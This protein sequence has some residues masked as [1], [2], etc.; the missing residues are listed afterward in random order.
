M[1]FRRPYAFLIKYFKII[2]FIL[3]FLLIYIA[4]KSY[5]I[6][7][8]FNEYVTHNYSGN[9]YKNFYIQYISPITI[10]AF[11]IILI[12]SA[13]VL[14]LLV[15]K[16]K[17][18]KTYAANIIY[19]FVLLIF[20]IFIKSIM[21]G[22]ETNVITA[23]SSRIYRDLA[24]LFLIPQ[25]FFIIVFI[26]RGFGLNINK[27][28]FEKD[29]RELEIESEDNE[30]V[31]I[32]FKNDGAK[33]K[34]GI[35]RYFREFSYY[36]KENKLIVSIIGVIL[37]IL[38]IILLFNLFPK[39]VDSNYKQGNVFN[40]NGITYSLKDSIITNLNYRGELINKDKYYLVVVLNIKNNNSEDKSLDYNNFRLE[41]DDK[42]IYPVLD[43]GLNFIDYAEY[44][45]GTLIK[46]NANFDY[47][48]VFEINKDEIKNN[49]K[50]K[51]A[52]GNILQD[53]IR[54]GK[55]NNITI[56]PSI[57]NKANKIGTYNLDEV[58]TFINSN[59]GNTNIKISNPEITNKYLY[60]YESCY[61]D[62]CS[63]YKDIVNL[64]YTKTDKTLLVL[65]YEYNVDQNVP[66][67][68][69]SQTITGFINYFV[70]IKYIKDGNEY[71]SNVSNSTP[72]N[73]N[74]KIVLETTNNISNADNIYF[75]IIIRNKEYLIT[76][77]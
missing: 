11:F 19:Y 39:K 18:I 52:S 17:P 73:L 51:F 34:R 48:L 74:G 77:K 6:M 5:N 25:L 4:Y 23:E 57:I 28:N 21:K 44:Y 12:I 29:I 40:Y 32:T 8:F 13:I 30:E 61:N 46:A 65:D 49:Y 37:G 45:S 1:I 72:K 58:V 7:S 60:T 24:L 3:S 43:K 35:R 42:N 64:D 10:L 56:T 67:Y 38:L 53:K 59:L 54:V 50:I 62:K 20:F 47:S 36:L 68:K 15:Y 26:L 66:F 76:V 41:I 16:K 2:N 22:M 70:K 63:T 69:T 9:Y 55:Y 33:L 14:W 71:Y 31:E 75:S 27:F